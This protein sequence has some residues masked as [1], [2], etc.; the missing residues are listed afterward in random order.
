MAKTTDNR[1]RDLEQAVAE[2]QGLGHFITVKDNFG[3]EYTHPYPYKYPIQP[4]EPLDRAFSEIKQ[5]VANMNAEQDTCESCEHL[6][7]YQDCI[8]KCTNYSDYEPKEEK[9]WR[10]RDE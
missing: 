3:H 10:R 5:G 1:I 9:C 6:K 8:H 7:I 2:L 4:I